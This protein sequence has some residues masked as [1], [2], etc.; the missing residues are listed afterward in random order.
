METL[1]QVKALEDIIAS[2][3]IKV[4]EAAQFQKLYIIKLK[5]DIC[6]LDTDVKKYS[7]ENKAR[8]SLKK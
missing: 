3:D 7:E 5:C 8:V 6:M 2:G 1:E 4:D